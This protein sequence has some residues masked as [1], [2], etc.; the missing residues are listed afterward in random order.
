MKKETT[1]AKKKLLEKYKNFLY[2]VKKNISS[3]EPISLRILV[4]IHKISDA[5]R[6]AMY[7][8]KIIERKG[9][10]YFWKAGFV[11]DELAEEF[12]STL[13]VIYKEHKIRM[14]ENKIIESNTEIEKLKTKIKNNE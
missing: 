10:K 2:A 5:S 4:S 14:L 13:S 3:E 7:K 11:T 9:Q 8:L 12:H 1:P 6:E